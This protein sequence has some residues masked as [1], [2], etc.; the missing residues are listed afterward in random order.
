MMG[1]FTIGSFDRSGSRDDD[2]HADLLRDGVEVGTITARVENIS[3]AGREV[4]VTSYNA[5][6]CRGTLEGHADIEVGCFGQ[7]RYPASPPRIRTAPAAKRLL[8]S[9]VQALYDEVTATDPEPIV[10]P[11]PDVPVPVAP[12]SVEAGGDMVDPVNH[13]ERIG[14]LLRALSERPH[15]VKELI[16]LLGLIY[17]T[18]VYRARERA[19]GIGFVTTQSKGVVSLQPSETL[20][21]LQ[22]ALREE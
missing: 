9:K 7:R 6:F 15:T 10:A 18:D 20:T 19:A 3:A 16:V 11:I 4:V 12:Q 14:I 8:L 2:R 1:R 13:Y 22:G 5:E 21:A 17:D